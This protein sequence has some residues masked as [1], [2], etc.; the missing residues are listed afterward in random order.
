[1]MVVLDAPAWERKTTN[2]RRR[3]TSRRRSKSAAV[4]GVGTD[5][6]AV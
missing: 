3:K 2:E 1:M 6:V 5:V 4:A